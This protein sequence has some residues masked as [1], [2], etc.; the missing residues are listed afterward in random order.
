MSLTPEFAT[1]GAESCRTWEPRYRV[2]N[3]CRLR[4]VEH[5]NPVMLT[6]TCDGGGL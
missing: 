2:E 6:M 3:H 4:V 5:D 1:P